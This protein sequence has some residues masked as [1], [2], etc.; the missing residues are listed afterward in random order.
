MMLICEYCKGT[1]AAGLLKC[2]NCGAPLA[3]AAA[4]ATDYRHC[5]FCRRRLLALGSPACNYCGR[6]LPED[7]IKAREGDLQRLAELE[8]HSPDPQLTAKLDT[9]LRQTTRRDHHESPLADLFG[10]GELNDPFSR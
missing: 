6:R 8:G 5:P 1:C 4:P 2:S 3:P 9:I 10:L 7:Y